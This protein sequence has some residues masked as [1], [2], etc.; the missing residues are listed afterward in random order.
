VLLVQNPQCSHGNYIQGDVP[1]FSIFGSRQ[2]KNAT[3]PVDL[4][5]A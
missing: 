1:L 2:S 5:P 4:W 3:I